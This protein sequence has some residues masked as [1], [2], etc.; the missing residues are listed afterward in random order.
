RGL[1]E[2]TPL[3]AW[4]FDLGTLGLL[5]VNEAACVQYGYTRA[6]FLRLTVKD[7]RPAEEVPAMLASLGSGRPRHVKG[8][9]WKH[10]K[11]DGT[12]F[13]AETSSHELHFEGRP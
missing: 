3:P 13:E 4:V 11:K 5:A 2:T 12:I 10:C 7:L 1:F 9:I 6:E 8:K